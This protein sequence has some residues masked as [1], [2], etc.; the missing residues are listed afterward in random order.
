MGDGPLTALPVATR[1]AGAYIDND[2][3][4]AAIELSLNVH[5]A[6]VHS[7]RLQLIGHRALPRQ[8]TRRGR[9]SRSALLCARTERR[10][11]LA[12]AEPRRPDPVRTWKIS[13]CHDVKSSSR[14]HGVRSATTPPKDAMHAAKV[15]PGWQPRS[16]EP[17]A[18]CAHG[19][20]QCG[21]CSASVKRNIM[22]AA[23]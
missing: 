14:P 10:A 16:S 1:P 23:E 11:A 17:A 21:Q 19:A 4:C 12:A 18:V 7:R 6:H 8:S 20:A 3:R 22:D 5:E 13:L 2:R 9:H 15:W